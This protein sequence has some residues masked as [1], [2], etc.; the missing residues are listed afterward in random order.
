MKSVNNKI[1]QAHEH[2][3]KRCADK[4]IP[5]IKTIL[6]SSRFDTAL[7]INKQELVTDPI[8]RVKNKN[9]KSV[10]VTRRFSFYNHFPA[11][12]PYP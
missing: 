8:H 1:K 9:T 6:I 3:T 12:V 10:G 5:A 7:A 11:S 2:E 4:V